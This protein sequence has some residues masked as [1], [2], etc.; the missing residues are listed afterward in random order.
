MSTLMDLSTYLEN[1]VGTL[2][3]GTNLF[4]GRMPDTPD[5]CVALY[6][7]GGSGPTEVMGAQATAVLENPRLQVATR[8]ASYAAAET[9]AR[10][11]WTA[12][13]GV[14]DQT[15][16]STRYNVVSAIQ[17]PFPLERDSSD[18]VVFVQNFDV[19][20]AL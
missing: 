19:T 13:S 4:I 11:V 7:Y 2:T 3:L 20:K 14:L 15:L 8:A 17:S 10:S 16:T 6:E 9:L 12:L 18:R 1:E 5:V